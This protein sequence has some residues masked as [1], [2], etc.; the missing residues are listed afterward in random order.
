MSHPPLSGLRVLVTR[1]EGDGADEWC[2][3]LA[4]A[5]AV[6]VPYPTVSIAP[7]AN[8]RPLDDALARLAG[9]AWIVFTSR[10]AVAFVRQRLPERRFPRGNS[11]K[12][13]AVGAATATAIEAGGGVVALLPDDSRQEGLVHALADLPAG[14]R[15]LLPMAE[16]GRTL[17]AESLRSRGCGVDVVIAYRTL[18]RSNLPAVPAFDVATFASPSALRA[19]LA[20]A[21]VA[22]LAGK[23]VAVIGATTAGEASTKGIQ[24]VVAQSPRIDSLISAIAKFSP[25]QGEP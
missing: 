11:T 3:A 25:N 2:A 20:H 19:Y 12:I 7:P 14:A 10:T 24:V 4:E 16:G 1:P 6:P 9:Y 18:P 15:L 22:S 21:G 23:G 13:A 5:G 8:W 17:L